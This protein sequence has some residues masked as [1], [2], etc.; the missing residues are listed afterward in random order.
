MLNKITSKK[1][2]EEIK[3]ANKILLPLHVSPDGDC[4]G[5]VLAMDLFLRSLGKKTKI[6]SYSKIPKNFFYLPGMSEVEIL[7][8]AK[9]NLSDFDLHIFL[10]I[11]AETMITRSEL[12]KL[13]L[14]NLK[15]INIDH[16]FTNTKFAKLNLIDEK[17]SSCCELLYE[18]FKYWKVEID[19]QTADLLFM[20][21][22]TD[23]GCFQ[24]P[25]TSAKTFKIVSDLVEKGADLNQTVLMQFRSYSL[26]TLKYWSRV[27]EN[28]QI[29]ESEKFV[30]SKISREELKQL[31]IQPEEIEGAA[32]LFCPVIKGTEFGIILD[33]S[34]GFVKGSLRSRNN[35]DV[36][37]IAEKLGGGGH[38][39]AAGFVI[40]NS[41]AEA[42]E[43][44]L[45]IVRQS[46][47]TKL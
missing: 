33:E 28:M 24:Y 34:E 23:S 32:S 11:A 37:K 5:A 6:I 45:M 17:T 22:F 44:V 19:K 21:I 2:L 27:L 26:K 30:W 42:E 14:K 4:I 1:I 43:K 8:F 35:F 9:I 25:S 12:P 41:L 47:Q 7:N 36:S 31:N 15:S 10:D 18:L 16:H 29:D 3:K 20:G 13:L 46:V 40:K 38:K 39:L